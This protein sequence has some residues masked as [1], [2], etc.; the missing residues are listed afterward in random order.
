M[1]IIKEFEYFDMIIHENLQQK[2]IAIVSGFILLFNFNLD[3]PLKF[4]F[5]FNGL[6]LLKNMEM[7]YVGCENDTI[8]ALKYDEEHE[9]IEREF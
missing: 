8:I 7:V 9:K 1:E 2:I 5:A 4:E 3:V 6:C